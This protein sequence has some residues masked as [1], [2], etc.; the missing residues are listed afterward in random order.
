MNIEPKK[1]NAGIGYH[2]S[3]TDAQIEQR[4]KMSLEEILNWLETT[5]KFIYD[6]QTPEER[7]RTRRAKN[8]KW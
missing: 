3:V 2:Y 5:S 4:K 8:F 7:E 6:I 1:E